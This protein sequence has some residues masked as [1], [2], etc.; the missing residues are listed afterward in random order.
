MRFASVNIDADVRHI[1]DLMGRIEQHLINALLPADPRQ[2]FDRLLI[3]SVG[4]V[5]HDDGITALE[6]ALQEG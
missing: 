5:D 3:G 4:I 6:A 2:F 1:P